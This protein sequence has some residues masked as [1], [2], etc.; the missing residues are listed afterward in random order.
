MHCNG[1][2]HLRKQIKEHEKNEQSPFSSLKEKQKT[3]QFFQE[4]ESFIIHSNYDVTYL[5]YLYPSLPE[6]K[7]SIFHPPSC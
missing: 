6:V 2:C 5:H 3:I 7:F 4:E 1:K